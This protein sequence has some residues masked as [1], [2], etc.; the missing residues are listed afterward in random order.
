[1][2]IA[3]SR[4]R[5]IVDHETVR[6]HTRSPAVRAPET[7]RGC[8]RA[9]ANSEPKDEFTSRTGPDRQSAT[10]SR[11]PTVR[12]CHRGRAR[13]A[14]RDPSSSAVST[15]GPS[16]VMANTVC[17]KWAAYEPSAMTM[18][19]SSASS[20]VVP[21]TERDHRLYGQCHALD[22]PRSASRTPAVG[23]R[24]ILVHGRADAVTDVPSIT[25]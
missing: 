7:S 17:S 13:P 11:S 24:W 10:I 5:R 18:V 12:G 4:R 15:Q 1:M 2:C 25:P 16:S 6:W 20:R 21:I 8:R 23:H 19:Q 3:G 9:G 22:Q 14:G